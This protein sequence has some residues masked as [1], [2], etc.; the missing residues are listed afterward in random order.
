MKKKYF[1]VNAS[2]DDET[3]AEKEQR[4]RLIEI[5]PP[6]NV[7]D[8]MYTIDGNQLKEWKVQ[9]IGYD[10]FNGKFE[11]HLATEN[12]EEVIV[13]R[14]FELHKSVFPTLEE[15]QQAL[16]EAEKKLSEEQE[17]ENEDED[18]D[19]VECDENIEYG[20]CGGCI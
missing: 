20:C 13:V 1:I 14:D 7:F 11:M 18:E 15:A 2:C 5:S 3:I 17:T 19:E 8:T 10:C 16:A 9:Y 4:E 6:Y 12:Y